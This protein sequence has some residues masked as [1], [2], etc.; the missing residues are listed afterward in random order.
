MTL[1]HKAVTF[2]CSDATVVSQFWSAVLGRPI[3]SDPMPPSP[4]FASIALTDASQL[5]YMFIQVPEGKSVK[6]RVHLDLDANADAADDTDADDDADADDAEV[7]R[8]VALGATHIYDKDEYDMQWTTL[9]DPEG[10]EFCIG[11]PHHWRHLWPDAQLWP[12]I[13]ALGMWDRDQSGGG[14]WCGRGQVT[15]LTSG[16][17]WTN[18]ATFVVNSSM[19]RRRVDEVSPDEC[20]VMMTLGRCHRALSAGKGSTSVTSSEAHP[21]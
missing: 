3:D 20:G 19:A 5:G 6:N 21:T 13:V 15:S 10:N 12:R 9:A 4:F 8:V 2:D 14:A 16:S 1:V 17:P 11:T 18:R 7:A